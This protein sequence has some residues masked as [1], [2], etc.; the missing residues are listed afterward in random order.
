LVFAID[1]LDECTPESLKS[2]SFDELTSESELANLI[3]LLGEALC[4]PDLPIIH[5][6]LMSHPEEHIHRVM[7]TE[8]LCL[9]VCEIPVK[10]SGKDIAATILLDGTDVDNDINILLQHS[11]R[12]LGSC[13]SDFPQPSPSQLARLAS[14]VGRCFIVASMMMKFIDD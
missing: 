8:E 2:E 13:H 9:L 12:E 3:F 4:E 7:Q 1:A 6:L 10:T 5:I 14:Q 11:F